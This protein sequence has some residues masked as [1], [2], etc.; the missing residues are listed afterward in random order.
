M[1]KEETWHNLRRK[2]MY[3]QDIDEESEA[4]DEI[5]KQLR[6]LDEIRKHKLAL[7]SLLTLLRTD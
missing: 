7:N 4:W 5:D 2:V 3:A 6:I 1:N